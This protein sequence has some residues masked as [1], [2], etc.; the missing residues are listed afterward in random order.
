V[1]PGDSSRAKLGNAAKP[2]DAAKPG[3]AAKPGDATKPGDA[4]SRAHM[5]TRT[6]FKYLEDNNRLAGVT[7]QERQ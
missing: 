5:A 2:G 6:G 1:R 3:Y 4:K 7:V